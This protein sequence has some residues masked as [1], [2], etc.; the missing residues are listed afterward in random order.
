[1]EPTHQWTDEN[2][3]TLAVDY[4]V[5]SDLLLRSKDQI[6]NT[7]WILFDGSEKYATT[8]MVAEICRLAVRLQR[9]HNRLTNEKENQDG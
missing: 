4:G 3:T 2:G 7:C 8:A 6:G 9:E 1:M 5:K